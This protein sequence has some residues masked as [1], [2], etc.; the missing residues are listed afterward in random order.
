[1]G[2]ITTVPVVVAAKDVPE[3]AVIERA[4]LLVAQW[5]AGTQPVGAFRT[6]DLVAN[7]KTRVAVYKG[8]AIV[9]GRLAPERIIS[10]GEVKIMPG[11]RAYGI[12]I[13]DVASLPSMVKPNSHVDIMLVVN[14]PE[15]QKQIAKLFMENMRVLAIGAAPE[16]TRDGR[17]INSAVVSVEVTPEEAEWLAIAAAGGSL[18]LVLRGYGDRGTVNTAGADARSIPPDLR[19]AKST[20][21]PKADTRRPRQRPP[22][23][24]VV[25]PTG[26]PPL[27]PIVAP[28]SGLVHPDSFAIKALRRTDAS[29]TKPKEPPA[30]ART[31]RPR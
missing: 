20:P 9:P 26:L 23:K 15:Q 4:A 12:R 24:R 11:K 19:R 2:R 18:Q 28:P 21:V 31:K 5:P 3:G 16:R 17:P 30:G 13:N 10:G 25:I 29:P 6:A 7:R 27:A 22:S 8:E 14:D 1:V